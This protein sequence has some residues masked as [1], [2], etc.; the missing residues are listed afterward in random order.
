MV[1]LKVKNIFPIIDHKT[2]QLLNHFLVRTCT[3]I[4]RR[5]SWRS[6]GMR[7]KIIKTPF[8]SGNSFTPKMIYDYGEINIK[9]YGF[10]LRQYYISFIHRNVVN[11]YIVYQLDTWLKYLNRDIRLVNC[12]FGAARLT[13]N[14]RPAKYRYSG[15]G[16]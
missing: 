14:S 10:C 3:V 7:E 15:H 5:F 9:F 13:K 11:S 4:N 2:F 8:P 12:S 6:K 16:I 1:F